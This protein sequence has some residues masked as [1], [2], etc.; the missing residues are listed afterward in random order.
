M[1]MSW[2]RSTLHTEE[3]LSHVAMSP[4]HIHPTRSVC[5]VRSGRFR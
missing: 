4:V 2:A 5:V 3:S 1:I